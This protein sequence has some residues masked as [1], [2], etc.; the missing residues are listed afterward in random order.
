MDLTTPEGI[1][2]YLQS[3]GYPL[4]DSVVRLAEGF[5]GFVYRAQISDS[6]SQCQW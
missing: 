5:S 2:E 1:Q 3:R 4:C 6:G